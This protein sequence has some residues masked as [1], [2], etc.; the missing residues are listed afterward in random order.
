MWE[1]AR[2]GPLAAP[3]LRSG[4]GASASAGFGIPARG[5]SG[6][7]GRHCRF[8]EGKSAG[9]SPR[10]VGRGTPRE[11]GKGMLPPRG[12]FRK[13]SSVQRRWGEGTLLSFTPSGPNSRARRFRN[14]QRK[15]SFAKGG[16]HSWNSQR[17]VVVF[18]KGGIN[19]WNSLPLIYVFI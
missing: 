10:S 6:W 11:R 19:L 4:G 5:W 7:A 1:R 2:R 3:P 18:A 14:G 8:A 9:P 15:E 16:D 17:K 12:R 13:S